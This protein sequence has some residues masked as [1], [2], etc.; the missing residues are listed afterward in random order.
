MT[1]CDAV[2]RLGGWS[3]E[4]TCIHGSYRVHQS[5]LVNLLVIEKLHIMADDID[6]QFE[7]STGIKIETIL[8]LSRHV[9]SSQTP[10]MTLHAIGIPGVMPVSYTH[11]TLPTIYSV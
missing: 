2:L 1:L 4:F 3:E 5:G 6:L 8:V 10:A 7:K 11:L 9:S